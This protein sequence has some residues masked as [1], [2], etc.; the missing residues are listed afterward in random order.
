MKGSVIITALF[1]FN[2]PDLGLS[3]FSLSYRY[4]FNE[5]MNKTHIILKHFGISLFLHN[6]F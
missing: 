4:L 1:F 2:Q 3:T 5:S 6:L